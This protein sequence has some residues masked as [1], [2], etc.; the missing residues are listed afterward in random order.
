MWSP[1][2]V[3]LKSNVYVCH[4]LDLPGFG[5]NELIAESMSDIAL[6][7]YGYMDTQGI[8]KACIIGHSM[9]GYVALEMLQLNPSRIEG[10]GLIHS[11]AAEDSEEKKENRRKLIKFV[12]THS[13]LTFLK[14]FAEQLI[15]PKH[16]DTELKEN[17]Y[18]LVKSTSSRAI[19]S[20]SKAMINRKNHER[21]LNTEKP[22]LWIIG[23]DDTFMPYK[24][25]L[26]Q[27]NLNQSSI[28]AV[29]EGVGH[30]CMYESAEQTRNIIQDFLRFVYKSPK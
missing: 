28:I 2:T 13:P 22:I 12:E 6:Y 10:I 25:V 15:S 9:G 18:D 29:L 24:E 8:D 11:H 3:N 26:R 4:A 23:E 20:S 7:V 1:L 27:A 5:V 16:A 30:L 19:I 14:A 17:A 21:T